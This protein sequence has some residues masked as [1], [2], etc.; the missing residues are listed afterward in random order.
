MW[1][2]IKK[3]SQSSLPIS[4]SGRLREIFWFKYDL[5]RKYYAA[6]QVQ[7]HW[8]SNS[9]PPDHDSTF[10]VTETLVLITQ[11][12]VTCCQSTLLCS[13]LQMANIMYP[14]ENLF[15]LQLFSDVTNKKY[16]Y[17]NV[18]FD[19]YT[20]KW[21]CSCTSICAHEKLYFWPYKHAAKSAS[22][23]SAQ[24]LH[25]IR[26]LGGGKESSASIH[27]NRPVTWPSL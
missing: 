27:N 11:P 16:N 22:I 24:E 5:G 8:G 19:V 15:H 23:L 25:S 20:Y 2:T 18:L 26:R 9:W 4:R 1:A 10:H 12:S 17:L 7:L 14:Q 3:C 13:F 6:F 21:V